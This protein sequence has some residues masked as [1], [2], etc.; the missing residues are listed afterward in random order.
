MAKN[1]REIL[2]IESNKLGPNAETAFEHPTARGDQRENLFLELLRRHV[3]SSFGVHKAEVIDSRGH[4]TGELDAVIYD[5]RTTAAVADEAGRKIVRVEAVAATVEIKSMLRKE[6]LEQIFEHGN[7]GLREL[8]RFYAPTPILS[9]VSRRDPNWS[10]S[11]DLFRNGLGTTAHHM[12]IPEIPGFAFGFDGLSKDL[13]SGPIQ[14]TGVDAVCVL[15]KYAAAKRDL[16]FPSN[17]PELELWAEGHDALGA[18]MFLIEEALDK[19]LES[20]QWVSPQWRR[21]F[22][23]PELLRRS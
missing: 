15:G 11:E 6:D 17:P 22:L 8:R 4:T 12:N 20:R 7:K 3:G 13:V 21:Y 18:F 9:L 1:Y 19:Y 14:L 23:S 5:R 10:K 16:G 2:R